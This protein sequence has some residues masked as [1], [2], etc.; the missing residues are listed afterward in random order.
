MTL[1]VLVV[2]DAK[3]PT[4]PQGYGGSERM[5]AH[6]CEALVAAGHEV[7]LIAARGSTAAPTVFSYPWAGHAWRPWRAY[8]KARFCLALAAALMRGQDVMVTNARVDY[9][10]PALRLGLPTVYN[11]QIPILDHDVDTLTEA[12]QGPLAMV[13]VS[14]AQRG[15]R[16][17]ADWRVIHN[18]VDT[19]ALHYTA[20]GSQRYLAFLGRLSPEKGVDTAIRVARAAGLPL[21]LAGNISDEA[22]GMEY[23]RTEIAPHL[24]SDV[25]WIGE[26]TEAQKPAFLGGAL[27]LLMPARW[28]E[29]FGIVAAEA[30]ACGTPVVASARGALPELITHGVTGYLVQDEAGMCAAVRDLA[31]IDRSA[32]RRHAEARFSKTTMTVR[33][34]RLVE[35][36][37][38]PRKATP[39]ILRTS[40]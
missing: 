27:A 23:F 16:G 38:A 30:L 8:C 26:I 4:P 2:A 24:G 15:Q 35:T 36:L 33:Y 37:A 39:E 19:E 31:A 20:S 7:T 14:E 10:L 32:C 40:P 34:V 11:F 6:I 28:N 29:P 9:L 12:A 21:V 3:L 17:E 13:A 18:G 1:R 22:G 25:I 5:M